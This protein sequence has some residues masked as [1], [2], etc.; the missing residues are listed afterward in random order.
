[1]PD[2]ATPGMLSLLTHCQTNVHGD[3]VL[4]STRQEQLP[5]EP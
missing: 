2:L 4:N 5:N 1:M 3:S